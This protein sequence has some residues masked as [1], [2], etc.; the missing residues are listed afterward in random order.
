MRRIKFFSVFI[1]LAVLLSAGPGT[2]VGQEPPPRQHQERQGCGCGKSCT[3][4]GHFLEG[5]TIER[6]EEV[7]GRQR[8]RLVTGILNSLDVQN[9]IQESRVKL[10]DSKAQVVMH[11]LDS[12][13]TLLAVGVPTEKGA[14]IYYEVAE[15]LGRYKSQ[16]MLYALE[17][18]TAKLI[19]TS[20]NQR[21]VSLSSG[22]AGAAPTGGDPC[23]GCGQPPWRY[24]CYYCT[25]WNN[26]CLVRCGLGCGACAITC[27]TG[28]FW[29]CL[30]CVTAGCPGCLF[31]CCTG[32]GTTCCDCPSF[33]QD[34]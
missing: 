4:R 11:T 29:M 5:I 27:A 12:G 16:A 8:D 28:N 24:Y 17:G 33:Q 32:W 21:L 26:G 23:G 25:S 19:S 9:V 13:N 14:L 18:D 1:L 10:D 30:F 7:T 34:R 2:V 22:Q 3:S 20:V 6:S 15:S 31:T